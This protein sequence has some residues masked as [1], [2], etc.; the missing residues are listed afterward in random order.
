MKRVFHSKFAERT[1]VGSYV[2]RVV[3]L[4]A[5]ALLGLLVTGA[6]FSS[7]RRTEATKPNVIF[8][9]VD[10]LGYGDLGSYGVTDIRTPHL[11]RLAEDGVKLTDCY[12]NDP[13]YSPT[14]AAFVT[15]RYQQRVG[16]ERAIEPGETDVGLPV[17]ET[18]IARM[19][20]DRGYTTALFGK[21]HLG[22]KK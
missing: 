4:I 12:S 3:S 17:S 18:S 19:L 16:F 7:P 21:W 2:R 1:M 11:D 9:L 6:I 13:V 10:D 15:G 5:I 20:K 22:Y 8:I 14:R